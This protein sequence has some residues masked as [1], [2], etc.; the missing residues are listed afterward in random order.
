MCGI[1]GIADLRLRQPIDPLALARMSR[2]LQHRGP[3]DSGTYI[4]AGLGLVARRL[5]IVDLARGQ[6]PV[7]NEDKSV[8]AV[9]NGE[10]FDYRE[11]RAALAARG[12]RIRS[13]GD[14]ELIV[15]LWEEHGEEFLQHLRGQFAL[16][17]FDERRQTLILARDRVGI[18]PLHW[19]VAG[20]H[21]LFGSEIKAILASGTVN[22]QVDLRGLDQILT[23]FCMTG[24]RTAFRG[25]S[26]IRPGCCLN[27]QFHGDRIAEISDHVYWDFNFPDAG[28]EAPLSNGKETP[29]RFARVFDRA[30]ALRLHAD[31][32]TSCYLSGG[33]DSSYMV[34]SAVRETG[35]GLRT[36]TAAVRGLDESPL[37]EELARALECRHETV[38][39]DAPALAA[40]FPLVVRA[41]DSPIAD[42]NCGSLLL[43]SERIHA[44]GLKVVLSGEGADEALAGYIWMKGQKLL[45]Y[46]AVGSWRPS[47]SMFRWLLQAK[48][49]RATGGEFQRIQ[50]SVGGL[51]GPMIMYF[52]SS[53]AR[54]WFLKRDILRE[55]AGSTCFDE[56]GLD[57][58][59][60][61][62]WHPLNRAL[63][64]GYKTMLPGLLL[65]HRGDRT[66]LANSVEVRYPFLDEEV[67]NFCAGLHPDWKLRGLLSDKVLLR[68]AAADRDSVGY[69]RRH[70]TMFRASFGQSLLNGRVR[71]I[72]Q[73]LSR[74]SLRRTGL[75]EVERVV[76]HYERYRSAAG[77]PLHGRQFVAMALVAVAG[78]QLWKHL[79]FGGGLCDLPAWTPP[80]LEDHAASA[81]S[82]ARPPALAEVSS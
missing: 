44:R 63:Y 51:H 41:G 70:K 29:E 75:F 31:V 20:D 2:A 22:R 61:R 50:D 35:P 40:A 76:R 67:I 8:V 48:Y 62:R 65:N 52:L 18:V 27:V 68:K 12:H 9:F 14:T 13:T 34:S 74:D 33:V 24:P 56:L 60:M 26:S 30:V 23:M 38:V 46:G 4:R 66:A 19:T 7:F 71:F 73:L 43:L 82:G 25:I 15:H 58:A 69:A 78:I 28:E 47:E 36:F 57:L 39:C 11:L 59:R 54:W 6:Q 80:G 49:P 3:D 1:A 17:L 79:Y 53:Y 21:L 16:A 32:P 81:S 10:L 42:P 77:Q 45:S 64:F 72:D 55:L 5:S 37:A